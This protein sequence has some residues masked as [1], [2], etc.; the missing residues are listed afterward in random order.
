MAD[1]GFEEPLLAGAGPAV[2]GP[3]HGV[4]NQD[5]VVSYLDAL[6]H[7]LRRAEHPALPHTATLTM[8]PSAPGT[9]VDLDH[10]ATP[11]VEL[12]C[13]SVELAGISGR[14]VLP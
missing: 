8:R 13:W 11:S 2:P 7:H 1:P 5:L 9:N 12:R 4:A 10:R 14:V 6:D 3:E